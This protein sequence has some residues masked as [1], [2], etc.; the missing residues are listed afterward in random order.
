MAVSRAGDVEIQQI[1]PRWKAE[2]RRSSDSKES[3]PEDTSF[4]SYGHFKFQLRSPDGSEIIK[5][6]CEL[7]SESAYFDIFSGPGEGSKKKRKAKWISVHLG[8]KYIL[9]IAIR[10]GTK[11]VRTTYELFSNFCGGLV[12]GRLWVAQQNYYSIEIH[13]VLG[14]SPPPHTHT[15]L[16]NIKFDW[17]IQ[18]AQCLCVAV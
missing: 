15:H 4:S 1:I 10:W 9:F 14:L 11:R 5:S 7:L 8:A 3:A 2:S 6:V 12:V 17:K 18:I 16:N 13:G